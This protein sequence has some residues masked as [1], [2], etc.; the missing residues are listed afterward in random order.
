M[1]R[2]LYFALTGFL[3]WVILFFGSFPLYP[4]MQAN[5][6]LFHNIMVVLGVVVAIPFV[7]HAFKR[8]TGGYLRYGIQLGLVWL[9]VNL[10][11]DLPVFLGSFRMPAEEYFSWIGSCYPIFFL[12]PVLVGMAL[13]QKR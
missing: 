8:A 12:L 10:G 3:L 1:N 13:Q 6:P 11:L 5:R 9:V 2:W 4:V 7:L